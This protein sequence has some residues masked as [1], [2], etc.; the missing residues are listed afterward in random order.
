MRSAF[1][2]IKTACN[3]GAVGVCTEVQGMLSLMRHGAQAIVDS[4]FCKAVQTSVLS[5]KYDT[6][7]RLTVVEAESGD[8]LRHFIGSDSFSAAKDAELQAVQCA[9]K[10]LRAEH[11][12]LL[13]QVA[14][15]RARSL[16]SSLPFCVFVKYLRPAATLFHTGVRK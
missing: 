15:Q 5:E 13:R 3:T 11:D 6:M 10:K 1:D 14:L 16:V 2:D 12:G 7:Q 9:A 8:A 4:W